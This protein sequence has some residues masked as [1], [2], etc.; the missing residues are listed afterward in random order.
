MDDKKNPLTNPPDTVLKAAMH[1]E[2]EASFMRIRKWLDSCLTHELE[3]ALGCKGHWKGEI[4]QGQAQA[5]FHI[6]KCLWFS[7]G[8]IGWTERKRPAEKPCPETFRRERKWP[9]ESRSYP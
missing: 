1:L 7:P 8:G 3:T 5:L 9:K 6:C 2:K 4:I